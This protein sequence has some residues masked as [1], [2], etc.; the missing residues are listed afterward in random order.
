MYVRVC[1]HACVRQIT[2]AHLDVGLLQLVAVDE[3]HVGR[4]HAL[5]LQLLLRTGRQITCILVG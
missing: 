2:R 5:L 1:M 3:V 4:K